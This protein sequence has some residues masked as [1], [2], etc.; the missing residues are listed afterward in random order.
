MVPA[1]EPVL[2]EIPVV[3]CNTLL[4]PAVDPLKCPLTAEGMNAVAVAVMKSTEKI[5][6]I[7]VFKSVRSLIIN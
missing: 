7:L 3:V 1:N 5:R 2:A 6:L 4:L